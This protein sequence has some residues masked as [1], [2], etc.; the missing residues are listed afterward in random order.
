LNQTTSPIQAFHEA[1]TAE[2]VMGPIWPLCGTYHKM[3]TS[4]ET[5]ALPRPTETRKGDM[6]Y[7]SF[8]KTGEAVSVIGVGGSNISAKFQPRN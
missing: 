6:L 3:Y 7:R 1:V 5:D 2:A 8:G 4:A